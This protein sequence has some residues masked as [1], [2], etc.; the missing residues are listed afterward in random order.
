MKPKPK[1]PIVTPAKPSRKYRSLASLVAFGSSEERDLWHLRNSWG[2]RR[3]FRW[4]MMMIIIIIIIIIT[5][6]II[7]IMIEKS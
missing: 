5:I 1:P 6:I 2:W 4:L 3:E 7:M